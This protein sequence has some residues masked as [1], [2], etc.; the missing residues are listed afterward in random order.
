MP[1]RR[2]LT[3]GT[4]TARVRKRGQNRLSLSGMSVSVCYTNG[5]CTSSSG[6]AELAEPPAPETRVLASKQELV[7]FWRDLS[8][9]LQ[10]LSEPPLSVSSHL[11]QEIQFE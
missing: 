7:K 8:L 5:L 1:K 9:A 11:Q 2:F 3:S 6:S 10:F 4:F